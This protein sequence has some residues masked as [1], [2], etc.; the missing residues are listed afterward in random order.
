MEDPSVMPAAPLPLTRYHLLVFLDGEVS[1]S[2]ALTR[3]L[4]KELERGITTPP[5]QTAIDVW[6]ESTGGDAHA[7]YKLFLDLRSRCHELRAVIPDYAKSAATLLVMGVD[8]LFMSAAAEL[9]PL[10]V[11]LEHP[12][13]EGVTI[14]GLE[15][16]GSLEFITKTAFAMALTGGGTLVEI[17]GLPRAPVL[18][19]T[20]VFLS[21]FYQPIIEKFDPHLISQASKQLKIAERYATT[22]L[23]KR[24]LPV[25]QQLDADATKRLLQRLVKDYPAHEFIISRDEA[26]DLGLPIEDAETHP[27]WA[28]LKRIYDAPREEGSSV[29][30][31]LPDAE[32]E[33]SENSR[34]DT[35]TEEGHEEEANL[36]HPNGDRNIE[37]SRSGEGSTTVRRT[38]ETVRAKV[39]SGN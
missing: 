14:S 4:Q 38:E 37:E 24:R 8:K 35:A 16:A 34:A 19:E 36:H 9:G 21:S 31:V 18:K 7:T 11:Q 32:I 27:R 13:R 26:R 17:T 22:M 33:R 30:C 3:L 12:D 20:L 2:R 6:L 28:S 39:S 25:E 5:Q 23:K 15:A 1:L 29:I 10:D